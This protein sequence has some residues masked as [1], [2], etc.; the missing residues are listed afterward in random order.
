[1]LTIDSD[2]M[3]VGF[4]TVFQLMRDLK[5]MAENNASWNRKSHLHR[6]TIVATD[7]IYRELYPHEQGGIQATFQVGLYYC[8]YLSMASTRIPPQKVPPY[9]KTYLVFR[10]KALENMVK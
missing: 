8:N 5:G 10:Q 2:E 1:M 9:P 3:I 6:D 7:A 4:P